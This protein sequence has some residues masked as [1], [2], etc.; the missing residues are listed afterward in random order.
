MTEHS[1]PLFHFK[2]RVRR[3]ILQPSASTLDFLK[4][5]ARGYIPAAE[6]SF[7]SKAGLLN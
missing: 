1:T 6:Q 3:E 7:R 5:F 4:N 2:T